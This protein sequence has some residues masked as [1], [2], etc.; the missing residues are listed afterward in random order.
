MADDNLETEVKIP[1]TDLDHVRM[2]L[3][4]ARAIVAMPMAREV[5]F[6]LDMDDGRLREQ[7]CLLRLR[8]H[9]DRRLL[10]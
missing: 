7:G 3:Q 5:N 10:T 1:V 4:R 6:L 2:A 8:Q 9:G